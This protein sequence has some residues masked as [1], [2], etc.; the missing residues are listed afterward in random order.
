LTIPR[1]AGVKNAGEANGGM[2][3]SR[4]PA[5]RPG[6]QSFVRD[7]DQIVDGHQALLL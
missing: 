7:L 3:E 6:Q 1:F 4:V 5:K 2:R